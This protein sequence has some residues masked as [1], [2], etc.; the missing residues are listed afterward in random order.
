MLGQTQI[1]VGNK[2]DAI[3]TY[4]DTLEILE[5]IGDHNVWSLATKTTA[6]LVLQNLNDA[7]N[8]IDEIIKLHPTK[9]QLMSIKEGILDICAKTGIAE[10]D[11]KDLMTRMSQ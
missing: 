4:K 7:K 11:K 5:R 8:A 6:N 9:N 2:N 1:E 10:K 3:K